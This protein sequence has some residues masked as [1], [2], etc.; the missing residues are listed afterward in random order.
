LAASTPAV[1]DLNNNLLP[2]DVRLVPYLDRS[3]L[4]D[5]TTHT[6]GKTLAEGMLLVT[7]VLLLALGSLRAA[8]IVALTI[9][10][11]L[12]VTFLFMRIFDIACT[13]FRSAH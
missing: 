3:S 10:L 5:A 12:A 6:V 13:R 1:D 8:L 11:V 4:I 9:P 2:K 7:L